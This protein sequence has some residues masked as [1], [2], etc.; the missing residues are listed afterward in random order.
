MPETG[1]LT[2]ATAVTTLRTIATSG[3]PV[4]GFGATAALFDAEADRTNGREEATV[5]A[6]AELAGAALAR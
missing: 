1:G 4:V 3:A 6:I 2:L 5:D